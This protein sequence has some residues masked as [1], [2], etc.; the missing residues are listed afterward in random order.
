MPTV[1]PWMI[2]SRIAP[3]RAAAAVFRPDL[4]TAAI[5]PQNYFDLEDPVELKFGSS[6][7]CRLDQYIASVGD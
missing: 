4:Y 2:T 3:I 6:L 1:S 7:N 5:G